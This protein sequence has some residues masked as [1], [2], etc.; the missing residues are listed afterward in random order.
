MGMLLGTLVVSLP[1]P[2]AFDAITRRR[3]P[4][5]PGRVGVVIAHA[6][7]PIVLFEGAMV[8]VSAASIERCQRRRRTPGTAVRAH[9]TRSGRLSIHG[10]GLHRRG[11]SV[12]LCP[13]SRARSLEASGPWRE[14]GQ[15][16]VDPRG[17]L[18][19][20]SRRWPDRRTIPPSQGAGVDPPSSPC[21]RPSARWG[22]RGQAPAP[23]QRRRVRRQAARA[24]RR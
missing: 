24:P 16:K 15:A 17:A 23:L 1:C 13:F 14:G 5:G 6:T 4:L 2:I 3:V 19:A 21:A 12:P 7:D 11:R 18:L 22:W 8:R 9:P 10:R 20:G